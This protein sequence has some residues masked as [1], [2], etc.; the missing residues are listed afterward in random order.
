MSVAVTTY[1]FISHTGSSESD[2][3]VLLY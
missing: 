3:S 1:G 2:N